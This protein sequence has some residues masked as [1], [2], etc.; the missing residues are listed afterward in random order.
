MGEA[1]EHKQDSN[2]VVF[3]KTSISPAK[4][5]PYRYKKNL[6]YSVSCSVANLSHEI[7]IL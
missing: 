1:E 2:L 4:A 5:S 6:V 7:E 3:H